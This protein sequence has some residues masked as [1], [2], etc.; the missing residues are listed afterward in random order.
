MKDY[1]LER[2]SDKVWQG[3]RRFGRKETIDEVLEIIDEISDSTCIT[4]GTMTYSDG[5]G[6]LRNRVIALKGGEEDG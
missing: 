2:Y 6:E 5:K 3:G 1:N 4:F